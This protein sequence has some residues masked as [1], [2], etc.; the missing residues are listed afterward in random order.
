M[1][2]I[3]TLPL[4]G[5]S[6]ISSSPS[7]LILTVFSWNRYFFLVK[8]D[9]WSCSVEVL[10]DVV[11]VVVVVLEVV[12]SVLLLLL[13]VVIFKVCLLTSKRLLFTIG[14]LSFSLSNSFACSNE[15]FF[16]DMATIII[17]LN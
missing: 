15:N 17:K 9:I 10:V 2:V 6:S 12:L 13:L 3:V 11:V 1:F 16:S 8:F 14:R 4:V 7:K 5:V